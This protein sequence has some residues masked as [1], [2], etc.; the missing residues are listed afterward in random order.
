VSYDATARTY[1]TVAVPHYFLPAAAHLIECLHLSPGHR[2]LD[3]GSGTGAVARTVLQA[4]PSAC[5]IAA[6]LSLPMLRHGT[7]S[8]ILGAVVAAATS[9]PFPAQSFDCVTASFVLNHLADCQAALTEMTRPLRDGGQLAVTSWATGPSDNEPGRLWTSIAGTYVRAEL[10]RTASESALPSETR[11]SDLDAL[12]STVRAVGLNVVLARQVQFP[13]T[14]STRDFLEARCSGMTGRFVRTCLTADAWD[15]F[16]GD[17]RT[18]LS[19]A[20]GDM[21][22]FVVSVNFVVART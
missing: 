2:L 20:Y 4:A 17:A 15:R 7:G 1:D 21:V 9:L 5:V 22:R 6:D 3:V 19:D 13:T 10:L 12:R 11:L 8:G 16:N 14:M 18:A